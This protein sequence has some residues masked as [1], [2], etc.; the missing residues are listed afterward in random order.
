MKMPLLASTRDLPLAATT[1][2]FA[3]A[4]AKAFDENPISS[5][6]APFAACSDYRGHLQELS[7]K[8]S[9]KIPLA[10]STRRLPLSA[11]TEAISESYRQ[12]V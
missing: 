6:N 10:A 7:P 11:T 5:V 2:A 12:N 3:R 4:I 8:R 9:M 1:E